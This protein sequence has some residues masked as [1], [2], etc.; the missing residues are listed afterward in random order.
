MALPVPK[1]L[2]AALFDLGGVF[3]DSPF[4]AAELASDELGADPIQVLEV[5]FGPYHD[6]TDHPWHRLERA[7]ISLEAARVEI[8]ALGEAAG[9][10][11]DPYRVLGA[12]AQ[13]AGVREPM[14]ERVRTLRRAGVRTA[15]VTNNIKEFREGW[16]ALLPF[17]ELF[18]L[19]VD[20]SELGIRKP[21]PAIL[22]VGSKLPI[23]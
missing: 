10:D 21:N 19:L 13:S 9:I 1:T 20:S 5:V 18:D 4:E 8:I 11:A 22:L 15:L 14:V 23:S 6:D 3:I 16:L 2:D 17:D 12:L 7:E